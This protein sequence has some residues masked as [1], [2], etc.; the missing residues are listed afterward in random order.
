M[1]PTGYSSTAY[2]YELA[3]TAALMAAA[4][5][6]VASMAIEQTTLTSQLLGALS[7]AIAFYAATVAV[8]NLGMQ[9]AGRANASVAANAVYVYGLVLIG[10]LVAIEVENW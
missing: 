8:M 1:N 6:A 4:C 10:L 2:R 3:N 9:A 5:F 7:V